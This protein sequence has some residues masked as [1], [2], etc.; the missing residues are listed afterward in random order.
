MFRYVSGICLRYISS[1][2][3]FHNIVCCVGY[4]AIAVPLA[5]IDALTAQRL[6]PTPQ[7]AYS[8]EQIN[9]GK[10]V[11][12]ISSPLLRDYILQSLHHQLFGAALTVLPPVYC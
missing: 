7:T 6:E 3:A 2:P 12:R 5:G 4:L 8:S 9:E 1:N 11:C 10:P